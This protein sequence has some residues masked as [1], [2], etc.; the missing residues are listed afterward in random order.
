MQIMGKKLFVFPLLALLLCTG[1]GAEKMEVNLEATEEIRKVSA[2]E[3]LKDE[4]G[5]VVLYARGLCCPS[6]AIGVRKMISRLKFVDRKRFNKGV[7][8]DTTVQLVTVSILNGE[9]P[10][11][12]ALFEAIEE[13]G[14]DPVRMYELEVV[15]LKIRE[16]GQS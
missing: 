11:L 7:E 2:L 12:D 14:Y 1:L 6:C 16:L 13:A 15:R 10:D 8:L 5:V 3:K 4:T 9:S